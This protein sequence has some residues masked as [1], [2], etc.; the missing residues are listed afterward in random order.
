MRAEPE[1]RVAALRAEVPHAGLQAWGLAGR[2]LSAIRYRFFLFAG[3]IPYLLGAAWAYGR[4]GAFDAGRFAL[5]LL[6]VF[7]A[8]VGVE[9]FNE[10]FDSRLGTDR[11]FNPNDEPP[12][13]DA[14]LYAGCAAF[15][16]AAATGALLLARAGWPVAVCAAFGGVAA[17]FYVGP[18]FRWA[19]LGLGETVIGLS[20][21]PAMT[22]GSALLHTRALN[23]EA[24]RVSLVPGLL[25]MSL[26]VVNNIPDFH[27]D[28][29]VG[30]RN[31]VVR[32]DRRAGVVIYGALALGALA[33]T[34]S[35]PFGWVVALAALPLTA[36]GI[37]RG[38]T[39]HDTP[40]AF[41][42]AVRAMVLTYLAVSA[43]LIV[44]VLR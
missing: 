26:A 42:P 13:R 8:I 38:L 10:Y 20:Y 14:V 24:L 25:V 9:C 5:G 34:A 37:R 12:V 31:L 32:W 6:G 18:P 7:F 43:A 41:I 2:A 30:K 11:V 28:R 36:R 40:V 4:Q 1:E 39:T 27:Q 23:G 35:L 3:L 17:V 44:L 21:G 22:L 19:Y 29:L 15:A 16:C 33:L